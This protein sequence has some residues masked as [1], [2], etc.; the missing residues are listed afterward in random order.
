MSL[1][2]QPVG[3]QLEIHG[4]KMPSAVFPFDLAERSKFSE[5]LSKKT[6]CEHSQYLPWG[7]NTNQPAPSNT[8]PRFIAMV[9]SKGLCLSKLVFKLN[10]LLFF[11]L[12]IQYY[13]SYIS[14][15]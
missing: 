15:R 8:A 12:S 6:D 3:G 7:L 9:V 1:P 10:F 4:Q 5:S 2:S 13:I 11:N 14:C